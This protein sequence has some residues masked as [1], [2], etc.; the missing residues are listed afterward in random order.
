MRIIDT[1]GINYIEPV[2]NSTQWYWGTDCTGGD[3]FEA[4]ELFE[5][6][7][8][9]GRL[10]FIH[11][12]DDRVVEPIS[13]RRGQYFGK[14]VFYNGSLMILR[15]DFLRDTVNII[16]FNEN[17]LSEIADITLSEIEDCY[18]LM[19]NTSP[20]ML[21]RCANDNKFQILW[22][23]KKDIKIG[24]T[25]AFFAREDDMLYFSQWYENPDY[26]EEIVVR[27]FNDGREIKRFEGMA[28]KSDDGQNLILR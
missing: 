25:E 28:Y 17:G 16:E 4:A 22:P 8:C 6:G 11:R 3:L 26:H 20:L 19:L 18:N 10:V 2:E 15:A 9:G 24:D 27:D 21:T 23:E 5:D 13:R 12:T 1:D 7:H 14:P